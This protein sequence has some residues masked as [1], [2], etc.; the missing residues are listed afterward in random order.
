MHH[1]HLPPPPPPPPQAQDLIAYL[2]PPAR[3]VIDVREKQKAWDE[4]AAALPAARTATP[5]KSAA[6]RKLGPRP[7]MTL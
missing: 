1:A 3:L 2:E 6:V 5:F 7:T 4:A